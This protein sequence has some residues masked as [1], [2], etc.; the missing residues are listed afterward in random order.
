MAAAANAGATGPTAGPALLWPAEVAVIPV[1]LGGGTLVR[2]E[3][4][5]G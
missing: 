4:P 5:R 3:R 1:H 2:A